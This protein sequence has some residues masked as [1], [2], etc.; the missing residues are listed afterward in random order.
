MFCIIQRKDYKKSE[1]FLLLALRT[2]YDIQHHQ[3]R[4]YIIDE[5]YPHFLIL[6]KNV[7]IYISDKKKTDSDGKQCL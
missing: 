5:V 1:Q 7:I 4:K 6:S 2:A 3:A